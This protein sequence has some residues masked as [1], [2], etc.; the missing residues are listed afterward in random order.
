MQIE[1]GTQMN[2]NE[3][4][5]IKQRLMTKIANRMIQNGRINSDETHNSPMACAREVKLTWM[6]VPFEIIEV[7]GLVCR[8]DKVMAR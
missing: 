7:D 6:G 4:Q 8:I 2:W 5:E 3:R 1:G